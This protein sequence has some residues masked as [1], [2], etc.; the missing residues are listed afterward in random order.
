MKQKKV[1][2]IPTKKKDHPP[3]NPW[4]TSNKSATYPRPPD[5][6]K[7]TRL[8]QLKAERSKV[9]SKVSPVVQSSS[10]VQSSEYKHPLLNCSSLQT[11]IGR[12]G[13]IYYY[14]CSQNASIGHID[15]KLSYE[16]P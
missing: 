8:Q 12:F 9:S 4:N 15:K 13:G 3:L 14:N 5:L 10:P 2:N 7:L 6:D 11:T 16:E 1:F